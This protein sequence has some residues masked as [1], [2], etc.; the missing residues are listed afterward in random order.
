MIKNILK[1]NKLKKI[2][3]KTFTIYFNN[4]IKDY[5]KIGNIDMICVSDTHGCLLNREGE[6]YKKLVKE[7][8]NK[9]DIVVLLGDIR[10]DE[11]R[12]ICDLVN[13][14]FPIVAVKGNHDD[15]NQ[16]DN[17]DDIVDIHNNVFEIKGIK[18]IGIQGCVSPYK[19]KCNSLYITQEESLE[20][21]QKMKPA[22]IV[23]S[24]ACPYDRDCNL[25]VDAY[26]YDC[27]IGLLGTL[28][29]FY[30]NGCFLNL[31]GH[32]HNTSKE[33]NKRMLNGGRSISIYK[34][35]RIKISS[36]KQ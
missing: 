32:N 31:H 16:F 2:I 28:K 6:D 34:V 22:N 27:H 1:I 21:A 13:K 15:Y 12:I 7:L 36:K 29:Y 23:I 26:S 11:L 14:Q 25:D 35:E 3:P 9:C 30:D 4:E 10:K 24:H 33:D 5:D 8:N 20:L 19:L 17:F 18:I